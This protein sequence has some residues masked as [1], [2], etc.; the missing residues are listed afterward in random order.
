MM[1]VVDWEKDPNEV[2]VETNSFQLIIFQAEHENKQINDVITYILP[3]VLINWF[4][5]D[6]WLKALET[7]LKNKNSHPLFEHG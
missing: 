3:I 1:K 4:E 2:L 5:K 7:K 6:I